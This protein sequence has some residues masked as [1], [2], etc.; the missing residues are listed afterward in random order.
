MVDAI[1]QF[2]E[3]ACQLLEER[4][5]QYYS[6]RGAARA[7]ADYRKDGMAPHEAE[8]EMLGY[9]RSEGL[10]EPQR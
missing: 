3:P 1:R 10:P 2:N 7:L 4:N 5:A 6:S 9:I 8:Q